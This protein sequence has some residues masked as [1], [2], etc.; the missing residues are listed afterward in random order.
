MKRASV[1]LMA[2]LVVLAASLPGIAASAQPAA[3]TNEN[4]NQMIAQA[5][6]AADHET[7]AAYYDR[8]AAE[9]EKMVKL[10]RAS[11]NIYKK[12]SNLLHCKALINSYQE[13]ADQDR[14]L[15][16]WHREM[17]KKAAQQ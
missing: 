3:V 8:E 12:T 1:L 15:A 16:A 5:K 17:A 10:H 6:T 9:N 7:I 13:A 14:A 4:L 11:Q 2:A